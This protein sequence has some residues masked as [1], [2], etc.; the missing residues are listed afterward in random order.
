M[1]YAYAAYVFEEGDRVV[2]LTVTRQP[3]G[4]VLTRHRDRGRTWYGV[5]LDDNNSYY[6]PYEE[7]ISLENPL[8][9]LASCAEDAP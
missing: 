1:S 5:V 2:L 7:A 6:T 8:E 4:R 3:A 9:S